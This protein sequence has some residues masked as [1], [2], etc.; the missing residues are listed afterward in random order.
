MAASA[1]RLPKGVK[2]DMVTAMGRMEFVAREAPVVMLGKY[3]LGPQ[4]IEL[5]L[6]SPEETEGVPH[7][8]LQD[9]AMLMTMRQETSTGRMPAS[10]PRELIGN[11]MMVLAALGSMNLGRAAEPMLFTVVEPRS[12]PGELL[13][14]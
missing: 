1:L 13:M 10:L 2:P 9:E 11:R 8:L 5:E 4:T 14:Q 3:G 7:R 6:G 12:A